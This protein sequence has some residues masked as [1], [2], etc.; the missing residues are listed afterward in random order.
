M[1]N[2]KV[3][4]MRFFVIS[5]VLLRI[6]SYRCIAREIDRKFRSLSTNMS[7]IGN[8]DSSSNSSDIF[9][10]KVDRFNGATVNSEDQYCD[11]TTF[12]RKL[13]SSL[14]KWNADK[15]RAVWFHISLKHTQWVP[16]LSQNNFTFH[17]V[18]D[19]GQS[20][21]MCKWLPENQP[22]HIPPYAHTM[23]GVGGI[24]V[25]KN[26]ELL[27]V[28]ERYG[29]RIMR[30]LPGGYV[31]PGED[32][33]AAAIREVEEE[34]GIR[35]TFKFCVLFRHTHG[36]NF[37]CSDLYFVVALEPLNE[38]YNEQS[39]EVEKVQW[40]KFDDFLNDPEVHELN[41]RFLLTYMNYKKENMAIVQ[42]SGLHPVTKKPFSLFF[43]MKE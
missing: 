22:T 9:L 35:T 10:Y 36:A 32:L 37:N 27:V 31:E 28:H 42:E 21:V 11:E 20:I 40:V 13:Q 12:C 39:D 41:R 4:V 7:N 23:V 43:A 38:D 17:R 26:G 3:I 24:V 33:S 1:N 14:Q 34:T 16:V 6:C 29:S 5:L 8:A 19:T 30:K 18:A 25:N 2:N 15:I